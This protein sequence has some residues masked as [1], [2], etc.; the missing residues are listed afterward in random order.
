MNWAC[1]FIGIANKISY[2]FLRVILRDIFCTTYRWM[3]IPFLPKYI[4]RTHRD[5][6]IFKVLFI[7]SFCRIW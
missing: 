4:D 7:I 3:H 5:I 1:D 2:S 6:I